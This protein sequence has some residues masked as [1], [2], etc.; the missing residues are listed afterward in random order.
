[1]DNHLTERL[2]LGILRFTGPDSE[3]FLQGQLTSDVQSLGENEACPGALCSPKG[4]VK[5]TFILHKSGGD[6]FDMLLPQSQLELVQEALKPYAAFFKSEMQIL[7]Y[8]LRGL[9]A[10]SSM[11]EFEMLESLSNFHATNDSAG[12]ILL[13]LPGELPRAIVISQES[14]IDLPEKLM[15]ISAWRLLDALSGIIWIEGDNVEQFLPHDLSLPRLGAVSFTKGCYTGQEIVA[16]MHYRGNPKYQLGILECPALPVDFSAKLEAIDAENN[17]V[18][19]GNLIEIINIDDEKQWI[20]G[21]I[22]KEFLE[23]P[24]I[25][26]LSDGET[27]TTGV[28]VPPMLVE[29]R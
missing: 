13:K 27:I 25:R 12:Q 23:M 1:M 21:V 5:A 3:R 26:L 16:R 18:T 19:L 17:H 15:S 9:L 20:V 29:T 6:T 2:P 10:E 8:E 28:R 4:R 22:K 7:N 14:V 11:S 24:E